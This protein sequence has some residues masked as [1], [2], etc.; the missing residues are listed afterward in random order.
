MSKWTHSICVKDFEDLTGKSAESAVR[1]KD[2]ELEVCCFCGKD[3]ISGIY[4]RHD[5]SKLNY[6]EHKDA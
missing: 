2:P 1:M 6:C 5:P 4:I 3:T